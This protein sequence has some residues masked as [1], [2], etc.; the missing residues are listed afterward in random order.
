MELQDKNMKSRTINHTFFRLI[1]EIN[2]YDS[3]FD[4][5]SLLVST[6]I[7]EPVLMTSGAEQTGI[8]YS[9]NEIVRELAS[10]LNKVFASPQ[11]IYFPEHFSVDLLLSQLIVLYPLYSAGQLIEVIKK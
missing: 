1:D 8:Y 6:S 2:S 9:Q 11:P 7:R 3:F 4:Y 5:F 10:D